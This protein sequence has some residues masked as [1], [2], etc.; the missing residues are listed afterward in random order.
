MCIYIA[1]HTYIYVYM[2]ILY[3]GSKA[4]LRLAKLVWGHNNKLARQPINPQFCGRV[5]VLGVPV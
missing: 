1:T 4:T 2:D 5:L 3:I